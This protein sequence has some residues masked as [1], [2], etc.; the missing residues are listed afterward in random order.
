VLDPFELRAPAVQTPF[1]RAREPVAIARDRA[2]QLVALRKQR[3]RR[4]R[5]RR[6]VTAGRKSASDVFDSWPIAVTTGKPAVRD[7]PHD[8][9]SLNTNK[10]SNEPPRAP[11]RPDR[12]PQ[13]R[14][15]ARAGRD[16]RPTSPCTGVSK[17][18]I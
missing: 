15:R 10:S 13:R 11:A 6:G 7:R 4:R 5:R 14:R 9:P 1:E 16:L 12:A 2:Q 3:L 18:R 17:R 8:A